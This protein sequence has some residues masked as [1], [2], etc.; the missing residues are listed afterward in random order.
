MKKF[1]ISYFYGPPGYGHYPVNEQVV[2][3]IADCGFTTVPLYTTPDD[4]KRVL[5]LFEKY[6]ITCCSLFKTDITDGMI[7]S[8][9]R[10][11]VT[12]EEIDALVKT[13]VDD[14]KDC[15]NLIGWN[16]IDEPSA[17]FFPVMKKIMAAFRRYDPDKELHINMWPNYANSEQ[18][19][20]KDYTTYVNTLVKEL[21]PDYLSF[22]YYHFMSAT[23]SSPLGR[24][25]DNLEEVRKVALENN[26]DYMQIVLITKHSH[27]ANITPYQLQWEVNVDLAYGA[28][29]IS[30]FTF[31]NDQF[32]ERDGW[33]NACMT[34]TAQKTE[35]YYQV[36]KVNKWLMPLGTEL[37]AKKSVA[38]F[39]LGDTSTEAIGT[40]AKAYEPFG[41]LGR[42][43]GEDFIAGFFDDES[44]MI[45][46]KQYY[47][48]TA[49]GKNV[50]TFIDVKNGLQY[51]NTDT[52][53]WQDAEKDGIVTRNGNGEYETRFTPGEGILF[54]VN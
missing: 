42:C 25:F 7:V 39:H 22:D 19:Q 41:R 6:G 28:K 10:D 1:E 44:F 43:K 46:N 36:Q 30:Y 32:M 9:R 3:D 14:M 2:K 4:E 21:D 5:A 45:V 33:E 35:R 50:F 17:N 52:A 40:F 24:L 31:W 13:Y 29:R 49:D 34:S 51:F 48:K 37:F 12:D 11:S 38:V 53:L 47:E 18:M 15:K 54:R 26:K 23:T 8:D 16:I 20:A 27:Y